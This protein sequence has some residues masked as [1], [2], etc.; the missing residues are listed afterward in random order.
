MQKTSLTSR[1]TAFFRTP[2][3]TLAGLWGAYFL[4]W[5]SL[6]PVV[7]FLG[8]YYE[9]IGLSGSQIGQL[10]GL[11]SIISFVSAIA[12]AFLS[13][14]LRRR[15]LILII[16]ILGM[17]AALLIYPSMLTFATLLPV[18][19]LYSIFLSPAIAILDE[20]TL[21]ALNNPRDYSKVR[22][23]GSYGWG[24]IVFAAGLI[25]AIP[26]VP[27]AIMFPLHIFFLV[28]LLA[29]VLFLPEVKQI[30][31]SE[32]KKA[33]FADVWALLR[34]PGF[35][36]WMG[37]IF[38]FGVTEASVINFLFLHIKGIGGSAVIMGAA[39]TI[40]IVGEIAGFMVAKRVQHKVGS[41]RMIV[42]SFALRIVWFAAVVF[43]KHPLLI[44]PVQVLGGAGFAMIESGSVAYVNERSPHRIGTTAQAIRSAVLIRF[45]TAVGALISGPLY[46][47]YGS[48]TMYAIMGIAS[49]ISLV[50]ALILRSVER[51]SGSG[52]AI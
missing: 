48:A 15:K 42:I 1:L 22:V 7:P 17:I 52:A 23:G 46:Q 3:G 28:L 16:C 35:A 19:A 14:V 43:I 33:S 34:R 27:L 50:F 36:L 18:V 45:S 41:R 30:G 12:L 11:R 20:A 24:I 49:A 25:I 5:G 47:I 13:D 29:L 51:K 39:M 37:I 4:Y 26:A 31:T 9:S 40:A 6:A 10:G 44:L 21:R 2:R 8:L 32:A 38:L